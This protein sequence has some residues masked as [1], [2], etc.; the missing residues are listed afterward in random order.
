[1]N[2]A[3]FRDACRAGHVSV[4]DV[5]RHIVHYP[6]WE[7]VDKAI[8][9]FRDPFDNI[10]ARWHLEMGRDASETDPGTR[11]ANL[12]NDWK[13]W[14][15]TRSAEGF[16]AWCRYADKKSQLLTKASI[17]AFSSSH[18]FDMITSIP[19]AS[20]WI[21]Y[22]Q[23]HNLAYQMTQ[24]DRIPTH[25][26]FYESYST[27]YNETVQ[28]YLDFLDL[29]WVGEPKLFYTGKTYHDYYTVSEARAAR[30]LVEKLASPQVWEMIRHYFDWVDEAEE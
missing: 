10:V 7:K 11:D 4:G 9:L 14:S 13:V 5:H 8:H 19:C 17:K 15:T 2:V 3:E 30:D 16:K 27:D 12:R 26:L 25:Y 21:R 29:E 6:A 23:W 20:D 24:Q 28:E 18:I 22:A 1:M